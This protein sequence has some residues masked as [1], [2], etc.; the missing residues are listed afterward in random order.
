MPEADRQARAEQQDAKRLKMRLSKA[1]RRNLRVMNDLE[2]AA[3]EYHWLSVSRTDDGQGS[4]SLRI[5]APFVKVHP[6]VPSAPLQELRVESTGLAVLWQGHPQQPLAS[7][8][9]DTVDLKEMVRSIATP[10][11]PCLGCGDAAAARF[12][13]S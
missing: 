12:N 6:D 8:S 3:K 13:V 9:L 4:F 7:M 10:T 1:V 11:S 5:S 2:D